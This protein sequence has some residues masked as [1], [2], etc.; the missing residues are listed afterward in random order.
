MWTNKI[1]SVELSMCLVEALELLS[2]ARRYVADGEKSLAHQRKIIDR[3]D[4][5]GRDDLDALFFLEYLEEM[6]E[7]YEAHRDSLEQR[8]IRIVRPE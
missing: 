3:L 1:A 5:Q 2:D 8:V 4:R 7:Q 6:Q